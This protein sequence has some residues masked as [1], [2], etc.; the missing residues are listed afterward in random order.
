MIG[1]LI[2]DNFSLPGG[3]FNAGPFIGAILGMALIWWSAA[4]APSAAIDYAKR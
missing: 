2:V 3:G 1:V 4:L